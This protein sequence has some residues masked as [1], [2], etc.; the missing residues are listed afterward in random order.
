MVYVGESS[1]FLPEN[2]Q[3]D[4]FVWHNNYIFVIE[5]DGDYWHRSSKVFSNI[6]DR[7]IIELLI[8]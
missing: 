7:K 5:I 2:K 4:F 1:Y 8:N 6:E 3:W